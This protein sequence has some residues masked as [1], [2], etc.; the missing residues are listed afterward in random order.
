MNTSERWFPGHLMRLTEAE[1]TELLE[2]REVGRVAY[3][4]DLGPVVV[5]VN[6]VFDGHG[7]L[8]QLS[9][10]TKLAHHLWSAPAAFQIDEFDDYTQS[11]W[12]VLVRG[13]AA[14]V[15]KIEDPTTRR[16]HTWAEGQRTLHVRITAREITGRRLVGA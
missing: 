5:P 16:L 12:S 11:G 7:V 15:E 13:E 1:C 2:S 4:D 14:W 10:H 6:F 9:P 8:M 3:C